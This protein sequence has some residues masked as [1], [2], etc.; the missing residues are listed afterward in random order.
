MKW[1]RNLTIATTLAALTFGGIACEKKEESP[2]EKAGD[3]VGSAMK[4]VGDAVKDAGDKVQEAT[5]D[6]NK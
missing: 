1:M 3:A 5:K 2:V 6:E 4:D